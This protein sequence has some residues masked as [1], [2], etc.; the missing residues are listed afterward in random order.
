MIEDIVRKEEQEKLRQ[1]EDQLKRQQALLEESRRLASLEES[2]KILQGSERRA[3]LRKRIQELW[4]VLDTSD[5]D[6]AKFLWDAEECAMFDQR[7][8]ALYQVLYPFKASIRMC[9]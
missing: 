6:R 8:S 2:D 9:F 3:A 4:T 7:S 5:H 1:R